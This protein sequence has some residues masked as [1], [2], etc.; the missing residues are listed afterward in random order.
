[1][2]IEDERLHRIVSLKR[3]AAENEFRAL[4]LKLKR[5]D[6]LIL[7]TEANLDADRCDQD[8]AF[9]GD[10][11][12]AERFIQKLLWNL[13]QL[14]AQREPLMAEIEAAR[15]DLQKIIVSEEVLTKE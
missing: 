8:G 15:R 3:Q 10:F 13:K 6:N 2:A 7:E 9:S 12:A 4:S 14:K 5:L 1:M 11:L